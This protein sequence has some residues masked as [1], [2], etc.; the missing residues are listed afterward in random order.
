MATKGGAGA[1]RGAK[2]LTAKT[3]E[4][5]KPE[6]APYRVP[7]ARSVGLA[8]RVGTD[9]RRT[10]D[11]AVRISG[12]G[13]I[14]RSSL[15]MWPD[16]GLEEAR[17]RAHDIVRAARQGHDLLAEEE[18]ARRA[19]AEA[20]TVARL[21]DEYVRRRVVGRLRTA[22]EIESRLK[23]ALYASLDRKAADIKRRDLREAFDRCSDA[24]TER[25]AEKRRQT[26]G[27][28]FRWAV[29]QDYIPSDPS[30]GLSAYDAG[31]PRDRVL[32]DE[33]IRMFW[34][35]LPVSGMPS[36]YTDVLRL[37]L[38]LGARIGE[39]G[40]ISAEELDTASSLWTWRLPPERSKNRKARV[41]P[42]V[43]RAREILATRLHS[44]GTLFVTDTGRPLAATH[45]GN[46]INARRRSCP[47]THFTSHDLRRTVATHMVEDLSI[48]LDLIA[49]VLGHEAGGATT[50]TLRRHYVAADQV[51]RKAVALLAWD[52]R[53][54]AIVD[55]QQMPADNVVS[56]GAGR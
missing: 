29:S 41:T 45:I 55:G 51:D 30:A 53:V 34:H 40:G 42:V 1:T 26:V 7:D 36:S 23:R 11:L 32:S 10:W 54:A 15:G 22:K 37:Q 14:K 52:Q 5:M 19:N 13:K 18:E 47:L 17:V 50:A 49:A 43:G 12:S 33:E 2:S 3:L 44:K 48:S 28:M 21:I 16:V 46:A 56:L 24:G 39:I 9:G 6:A 4:A 38:L 20:L 35:W 8:V 25:E 27:A 31:T